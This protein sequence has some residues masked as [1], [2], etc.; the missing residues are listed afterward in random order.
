MQSST[1]PYVGFHPSSIGTYGTLLWAG[2]VVPTIGSGSDLKQMN[3]NNN[4]KY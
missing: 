3:N 2:V 4:K 1:V